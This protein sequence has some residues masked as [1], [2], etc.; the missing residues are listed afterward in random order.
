ME[1]P[2]G[3]S[4]RVKMTKRLMKEAMIEL[5]EEHGTSKVSVTSI[6]K[7]ADVNRSTFYAYYNQ[8]SD[9]LSEIEDEVLA[10]LPH[11][12]R[13]RYNAQD[14]VFINALADYLDYMKENSRLFRVLMLSP[15]DSGFQQKMVETAIL[16]YT[17]NEGP[18]DT[19]QQH[20]RHAYTVSGCIG[21]LRCWISKGFPGSS[22]TIAA[23]MLRMSVQANDLPDD[24]LDS[25]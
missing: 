5:M 16:L 10:K 22:K 15:A 18:K 13:D 1:E 7:Q 14:A 23:L 17:D 8:P 9:L 3:E 4:R 2:R 25:F 20:C 12:E 24:L 6:C 11:I 19:P 21:L